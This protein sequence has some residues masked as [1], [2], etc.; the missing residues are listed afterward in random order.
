[1][2]IR[3]FQ[4]HIENLFVIIAMKKIFF[5]LFVLA[6]LPLLAQNR[7]ETHRFDLRLGFGV[8]ILGTGDFI[9]CNFQNELNYRISP[10]F[11]S[12]VSLNIGRSNV[13][14]ANQSGASFV[15]GNLNIYVSPFKNNRRNDFRLG[16]GISVYNIS[17][18]TTSPYLDTATGHEYRVFDGS[19]RTA[20][21]FNMVVEYTH[22]I[23]K[24]FLIGALLFSQPYLNGDINS[25]GMVK[26]G[27][28][29]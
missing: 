9:A 19:R 6:T 2:S 28:V 16:G 22:R 27:M 23:S 24:K 21:G 14:A 8:T 3:K 10:Y 25:G 15:Q 29:L 5:L 18:Y 13:S 4:N 11:S 17:D 26:F 7:S 1:M 12:S 20:F